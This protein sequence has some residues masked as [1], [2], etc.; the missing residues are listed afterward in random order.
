MKGSIAR[1]VFVVENQTGQK[2]FEKCPESFRI[3]KHI[4]SFKN[5]DTESTKQI[6]KNRFLVR[7]TT[8]MNAICPYRKNII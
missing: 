8:E 7:Y 3:K 1:T 5:N 6:L 2:C 4:N